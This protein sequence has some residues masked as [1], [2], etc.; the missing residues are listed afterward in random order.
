MAPQ[1]QLPPPNH[2]PSMLNS[3]KATKAHTPS[4]LN[5]KTT[6][7]KNLPPQL[8][9]LSIYNCYSDYN[10]YKDYKKVDSSISNTAALFSIPKLSVIFLWT[11]DIPPI[12]FP[13]L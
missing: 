7:A 9:S 4:V 5:L 1:N 2:L 13:S 10:N 12:C 3:L 8:E 11:S 6:T